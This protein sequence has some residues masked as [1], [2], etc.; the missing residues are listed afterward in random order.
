M[1]RRVV[2]T[3]AGCVTSLGVD[4]PQVWERLVRGESGAGPITLFDAEQFPVRMAAEVPDWDIAKF[5]QDPGCWRRHARQTQ[6]AI[7]A[8]LAAYRA[9]GLDDVSIDPLRLGV[10]LGCG[11]IFPDFNEFCRRMSVSMP[12]GS[13][14]LE[15][16]MQESHQTGRAD[17]E[18]VMEPG[19]AA[20]CIA[21]QFDAQGPHGN[22][23]VACV[24]SSKAIGE[25]AE[26]I[27]DGTADV[28][29][30]GGAHSMIHP[31]GMTGFHRLSTMSTRND[32]PQRATR[33]FD[34]GRDGFVMGEGGA[35]LVLESLDH[36]RRRGA[37]IWAE[38]TGWGVTHDAYRVTDLEPEG[39]AAARCMTLALGDAGLLPEDIHYI[40]A[41][42]TATSVNDRAESLATKRALGNC[43]YHIPIS[44][45]KS[46]TG[47]LTTA[48]GAVEALACVMA[49]RTGVV[50]PTINYE[51]PDPDCDL[52]Y[53]P[54]TARD[55]ACRN[56]MS[57]SFGFGG[58]NVSLVFS[59]CTQ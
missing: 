40:N 7:V 6:F 50:P 8:A 42:G 33:P 32:D 31:F 20:A 4:V 59:H 44:S 3:G 15:R 47:H 25:A 21:G 39:R 55:V 34:R 45:T 48:C 35:I 43:A 22:F 51:D 49:L 57:N 19:A 56:V 5:V 37:E 54:N 9:T 14:Q 1:R 23:T 12:D 46:M 27:R 52:D 17:D 41:H 13:L 18:L 28:M 38:F 36:A 10:F 26:A 24:S 58:H 53:V 11:E 16:F 29:F 30:C 2:V